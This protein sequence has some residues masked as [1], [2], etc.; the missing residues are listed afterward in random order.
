M[1]KILGIYTSPRPHWVGDGFPVR[2]LF[3]Y[4]SLGKHISPFLLLDYA[5]PADFE[6]AE[7][8]R[9]VGQH[10]HRGFE[11]VTIVYQGELE[12]RDST[13][14][15]GRIGPGDVQWMTAASGI[16]HEEFHSE[17]FTRSGGTLEMVQLWVN[18]PARDKLAAP[19][20]QTLLDADIPTLPLPDKAGSLRLI[21]G[22]FA[23]Q[24]GPARTFTD[25]DVWDIR[26]NPGKPVNLGLEPGRNTALVVLRGTLQV[27]GTELVRE[28]QMVLFE[29]E[30]DELLL[31]ANNEALVLLLSGEPIDEPIVGYGPFVMNS[32]AEIRQAIQAFQAGEFGRMDD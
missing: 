25:M 18:L 26:L 32:Q 24:Q 22:E 8:P 9:G 14:A 30:G 2:T 5:G 31:E 11:T 10:P 16:L 20:Y 7:R 28:G 12:H 3:S 21:A 15:G 27:N 13:G 4:D 19:G 17:A 1:K 29:P 6:P 23:G